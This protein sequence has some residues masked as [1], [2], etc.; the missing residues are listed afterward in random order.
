M[1][2]DQIAHIHTPFKD[3][4]G[5]PRQS[6]LVEALRGEIIFEEKYRNSQAIEGMD[7][8]EYFWIL[9][10]FDDVRGEEPSAEFR[11]KVR[12]P[13]L[14]GNTY[15]GVFA[16]RSPFRPN[17]IGMSLVK[18][19]YIEYDRIDGPVIYV[20]G[21]D[22]KDGTKIYDIKPYIPY[23]EAKPDAKGGFT[24]FAKESKKIVQLSENLTFEG[25]TETEQKNFMLNIDVVISLLELDPRPGYQDKPSRVYG[26]NYEDFNIKFTADNSCIEI[27]K[28][29]KIK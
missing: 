9:W 24:N 4:F 25:L 13:K 22:M 5:I 7:E 10:G 26:M 28:I 21:I 12:P 14:G 2:L 17:P 23:L 1:K 11:P 18:L 16:T 8:F 29:E 19:E 6:G 15:K 20:S 27:V 3:K